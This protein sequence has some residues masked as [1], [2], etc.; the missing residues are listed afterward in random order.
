MKHKTIYA[1]AI[2]FLLSST[3]AL[4]MRRSGFTQRSVGA[5]GMWSMIDLQMVAG[6]KKLPTDAVEDMSLIYP[7]VQDTEK[8]GSDAR[9]DRSA[10]AVRKSNALTESITVRRSLRGKEFFQ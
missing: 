8:S 10:E 6:R 4:S 5:N 1:L 9:F 3:V 7:G 2:T